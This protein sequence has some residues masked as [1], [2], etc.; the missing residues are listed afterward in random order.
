MIHL[1]LLALT[2][3]LSAPASADP[4]PARLLID[5]AAERPH[6]SW[7][8]NAEI[9]G[10]VCGIQTFD[11]LDPA[12]L[13]AGGEERKWADQALAEVRRKVAAVKSR[14]RLSFVSTDIFV[15]PKSLVANYRQEICDDRGRIDIKRPKTR[16]IFRLLLQE[17]IDK[18]P[19]LDGILIRTGEVYLHK[20]PHHAASGNFSDDKRQGGT[21]IIDGPSSHIEILRILREEVCVKRNKRLLYRTWSFGPKSF[22]EDPAYYLK[23]TDAIEPHPNL[24]FS[25]KHQQ[26]DFHQLAPFN[27]TLMIGRHRQIIEVQSQREAYGKGAHPYYIGAGVIDGWEEYAWIMEPG[28]ARG[29]R[30]V[31]RHPLCAGIWTWSR[32]GGWEGPYIKSGLWCE[33]N[34]YVVARFVENPDLTEKAILHRFAREELKLSEKDCETFHQLCLLSAKAVLRGQLTTLGA[35]ID[36]WWAR[37]HFFEAP[38][39]ADFDR[40]GLRS[41]ALTEKAGAVTIWRDME[42]LA[43]KIHFPDPETAAF[44]RTSTTYGR[45]KY[46]IV[47][48]AWRIQFIGRDADASMKFE[49]KSLENALQQYDMLWNEWQELEKS[50]PECSSIHKDTGFEGRPGMGAAIGRRRALLK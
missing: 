39:L 26:G 41:K 2:L 50:R 42:E 35:K 46:A 7:G 20:Q 9:G 36:V 22:H 19:D 18:V 8:F 29:L 24:I 14:G 11:T 28:T 40:Q 23:V 30:D 17:T 43:G 16:E 3:A 49:E 1:R 47:E 38:E 44:V 48:Q 5:S 25:I 6:D 12:L 31:I 32:G 34:T 45:I 13:P 27:P 15:F 10:S 4:V 33:L 37:D 21:A